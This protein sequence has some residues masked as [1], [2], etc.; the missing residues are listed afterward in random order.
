[1]AH[2][3][4]DASLVENAID[5]WASNIYILVRDGG[6]AQITV[7][8]D[9]RGMSRDDLRLAIERHATSKLPD[10]DLQNISSLGFRGEALASIGAVSRLQLTSSRQN[11]E[12]AWIL[13]V[14]G[15]VVGTPEP[16][17]HP[18]GTRIDVRDLFFNTPARLKFLKTPRAEVVHF[19][20][21][22]IRLALAHANLR[23]VPTGRPGD[24]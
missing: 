18:V 1:M 4:A 13:S 16:I 8:D 11:D 6:R 10:D 21:V 24:P 5:A 20:E 23:V 22:L 17:A 19:S 15:G 14:T 9:G 3:P 2:R 12:E 7:T